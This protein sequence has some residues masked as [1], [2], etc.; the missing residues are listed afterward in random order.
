LA[1]GATLELDG[2]YGLAFLREESARDI[3]C[4]AG[5]SGLAPMA[6]ILD[7]AASHPQASRRGAWLFYGGRGPGDVPAVGQ[8]LR[9]HG[10]DKGL[11]WHPV[12][13]VPELAR[14]AGWAGETGF[15][16]ELLPRRLPRPLPDYEYYLAG[17]PPMIEAAVRLLV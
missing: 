11:Q 10:V 14:D 2:P 12:V 16:H 3:V 15:V 5:G 7:G 13:S 8:V 4:I 6:S 9:C 1:P 17:P